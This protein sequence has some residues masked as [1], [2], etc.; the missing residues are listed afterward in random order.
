MKIDHVNTNQ[1]KTEVTLI[2]S[3]REDFRTKK[4][5]TLHNNK[6]INSLCRHN[7]P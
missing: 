3:D 6:G 4:I 7:S 5:R 1:K 2:I